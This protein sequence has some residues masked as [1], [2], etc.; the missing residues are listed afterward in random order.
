M[1]FTLHSRARTWFD[2]VDGRAFARSLDPAQRE[3]GPRFLMFDAYYCCLLVGLDEG[4]HGR[5]ADLEPTEFLRGYPES[6][7]GQAELIAGLL[8]DAELRRQDILP[9]DKES[10]EAEMVRLLDLKSQTRLSG[11]GDVLLNFYA[12]S[13]FKKLDDS[14]PSPSNLE[15]F[16]VAYHRL[17]GS[18]G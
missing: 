7:R 2:I 8:V 6:Y 5:A 9:D 11:P 17:W 1:S 18:N 4:R 15:D 14:M 3:S 16:L 12:A 13:G 10:I